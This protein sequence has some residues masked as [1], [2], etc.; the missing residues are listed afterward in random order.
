MYDFALIIKTFKL[1]SSLAKQLSTGIVICYVQSLTLLKT[2]ITLVSKNVIKIYVSL[3][4]SPYFPSLFSL[5][6][7]TD[8]LADI[9][10]LCT[11]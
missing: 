5:L 6:L 8:V 2:T 9:L 7:Q 10:K 4:L 1:Q 3:F 11:L